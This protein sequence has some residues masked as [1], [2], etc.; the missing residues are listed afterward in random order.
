MKTREAELAAETDRWLAA[1]EAAD[2]EEDKVHGNRRGDEMPK[3]VAGKARRLA[4]MRAAKAALEAEAKAAAEEEARRRA[5]AQERRL[6]EG[7]GNN[8]KTPAPPP[9]EPDPK[10][11][12]NFTDPESRILKSKDGFIQG[13]NGQAAVDGTAQVIVAQTLTQSMSDQGQLTVLVNAIAAN[14]GA[15]PN[16]AE[17]GLRRRRLLLGSEPRGARWRATSPPT[18][19]RAGPSTRPTPSAGPAGR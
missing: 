7:R 16:E 4:R 8:G 19:P 3:W 5:A 9:E 1:A 17:R 10:A 15:R 6:A 12:K 2:A 11:Q 14:L 18:S 13:Y